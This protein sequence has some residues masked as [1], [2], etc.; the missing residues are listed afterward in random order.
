[1]ADCLAAWQ[2]V[3][4]VSG[5]GSLNWPDVE[6]SFFLVTTRAAN[7]ESN[8]AIVPI[9]D[10]INTARSDLLNTEYKFGVPTRDKRG[11]SKPLSKS[12]SLIVHATR[13]IQR[14]GEIYER[15]CDQKRICS[16]GKF[17]EVWG[18]YLEDSSGYGTLM[19]KS[20]CSAGAAPGGTAATLR[21]VTEDAL[22]LP[23]AGFSQAGAESL[24][25][26]C[27][28]ATLDS[29]EQGPIRCSLARLAWQR[30]GAEWTST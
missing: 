5:L 7:V 22:E 11:K 10:L 12:Q 13:D 6:R 2:K 25:P 24:A 21:A 16:N 18:I 26:R 15:Y 29:S 28:Q 3:S 1:M 27:K 30:C 8:V 19:P 20:N 9:H 4:N 17:L 14:G 23:A